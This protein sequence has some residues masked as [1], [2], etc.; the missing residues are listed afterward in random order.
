MGFWEHLEELRGTIIKSLVVFVIAATL[1][2]IFCTE[3]FDVL[4][5]PLKTVAKDYPQVDMTL[6]GRLSPAWGPA[7]P[8]EVEVERVTDGWFRNAGPM[9]RGL[10]VNLGRTAVLLAGI[11]PLL[12]SRPRGAAGAG[13]AVGLSPGA[14]DLGLGVP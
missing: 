6:G 2:G 12:E 5:W 4:L 7:V 14:L 11:E 8:L 10:D 3:C 9:E 13:E 1:V